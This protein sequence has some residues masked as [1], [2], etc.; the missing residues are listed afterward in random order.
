MAAL[1]P[2]QSFV[3]LLLSK[4]SLDQCQSFL[5]YAL[6]QGGK[7]RQVSCADLEDV[8]QFL[9]ICTTFKLKQTKLLATVCYSDEWYS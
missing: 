3:L 7:P 1:L 9:K 5:T 2:S 8:L 6:I 4:L